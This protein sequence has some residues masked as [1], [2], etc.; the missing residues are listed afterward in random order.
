MDLVQ[1][2]S[3]SHCSVWSAISVWLFEM[4]TEKCDIIGRS[5]NAGRVSLMLTKPVG[6]LVLTALALAAKIFRAKPRSKRVVILEP[7]GMGDVIAIL[8][9][10]RI[11]HDDGWHVTLSASSNWRA[12]F[13]EGLIDEWVDCHVPWAAR[14]VK[15]KYR[16]SG[17]FGRLFCKF[18][19]SLE[20]FC[21]GAIGIEP[22]GDVRSIAL[23][24]WL[25][26][27]SVYSAEYYVGT[28]L[29]V[30][31][32]IAVLVSSP[33]DERRW[34]NILRFAGAL[35][36]EPATPL[37]PL[38]W[39]RGMKR[40]M[41]RQNRVALL[42]V[43]P[44]EGREWSGAGWRRLF[45]FL[46]EAGQS[47]TVL[48]GPGQANIARKILPMANLSELGSVTQ[49]CESLRAFDCA[50]SLD[51]GPM[52]LADA[53]GIPQVVLFGPGQLPLWAPNCNL[54]RI[55]H[56]QD[57]PEFFPVQQIASNIRLGRSS[58]ERILPEEVIKAV[59]DLLE[60][61]RMADSIK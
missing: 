5:H 1:I 39:V 24:W 15:D 28:N 12:L 32:W 4:M 60:D 42:P 53:L 6:S 45:A 25:G 55:V 17:F 36:I 49:W 14:Q 51:S 52:H 58:M 59:S 35:G 11:L 48:C 20:P 43:V 38:I 34:Q 40:E 54:T 33:V 9:L 8:P 47:C 30:S 18:M 2:L 26:C 13:E 41:E 7:F 61:L 23:L 16:L 57:A 19:R 3:R 22:R 56:H 46:V 44:W 29:R 27:N 21:H 31:N 10:V 50:I 37:P